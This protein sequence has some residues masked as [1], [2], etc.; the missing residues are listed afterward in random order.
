VARLLVS[1][2]FFGLIHVDPRQGSMAAVMGLFLYFVYLTTRS[3]WMPMLI[4]FLNNSTSVVASHIENNPIDQNPEDIP[5]I[6]FAAGTFLLVAILV[7]LYKTRARLVR[8]ES[9]ASSWEPICVGIE[10]PPPDSGVKVVQPLPSMPIVTLVGTGV[11]AF[12]GA[13]AYSVFGQ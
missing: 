6:V 3:L 12:V 4:H 1:S 13:V 11:L 10:L 8:E 2:F 7:A 5:L 9:S